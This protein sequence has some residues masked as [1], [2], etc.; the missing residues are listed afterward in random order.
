MP[1]PLPRATLMADL[2]LEGGGVKGVALVGAISGLVDAGYSFGRIAGT[3]AG[4]IVGSVVAAMSAYGEPLT[5]LPEVLGTLD[6]AAMADRGRPGQ[7]LNPLTRLRFGRTAA[8]A[9]NIMVESA[10]FRG[11]RLELWLEGILRDFRVSTFGDLLLDDPDASPS[12]G[13]DFRLIA[14]ASDLTRKRLTRLPW[15]YAVYGLHPEDQSV[16][17]AVRASS[18]SPFLFRPVELPGPRGTATLV[19]GGLLSNYPID[20]FDRHD[21]KPSRW[22]TIGIRLDA[23]AEVTEAEHLRP[24]EGTVALGIAV[25]E[26]A[27]EGNQAEH[28]LSLRNQARSIRIP[29]DGIGSFDFHLTDEERAVLFENGY[30]AAQEFV[31][32]PLSRDAT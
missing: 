3:S 24:I 10:A 16:A 12:D 15:D 32:Q 25:I 22:P 4:A 13:E 11:D 29:S 1:A 21:G 28:L 23:Q 5:A 26:T 14:L 27:I 6:L 7:L 18:A 20:V 19:D 2:V 9:L 30:R 8:D 31:A 17:Q